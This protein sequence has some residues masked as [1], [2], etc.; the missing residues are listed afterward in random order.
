MT[1][2]ETTITSIIDL[3]PFLRKKKYYKYLCITAI[4][5]LHLIASINLTYDSGTYWVG[6]SNFKVYFNNQN[7]LHKYILKNL[8]TI[9]MEI[10]VFFSS[11][12][13]SA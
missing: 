7:T 5:V 1:Q 6:K 13:L 10:G 2:I 8:L 11:A 4:C 3:V 12:F 9:T